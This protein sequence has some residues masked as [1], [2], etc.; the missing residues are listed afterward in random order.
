MK[1]RPRLVPIAGLAAL[2]AAPCLA[3]AQGS[4]APAARPVSF[5]RDIRPLLSN[6]CSACHGP[7][8]KARKA[9]LRLDT[10][11]GVLRTVT[12]YK[13][14]KSAL[15]L[16][17]KQTGAGQ[18]PPAGFL[19]RPTAQQIDLVEQWI[20]QGGKW[21]QH[22]AYAPLAKPAVPSLTALVS[23]RTGSPRAAP[24]APRSDPGRAAIAGSTARRRRTA[25]PPERA[26]APAQVGSAA[27]AGVRNEIDR[28]LMAGLARA[29]VSP[30]PEADRRTLLRR[31]SFD[32]TG[33]P[34]TFDEVRTFSADRSPDAYDR[35]VDRLLASDRFG[36]RMAVVWLDLVRYA[37]TRGYHGDQN[38][39][40]TPYRD[41]V[42]KSFNDNK[43]FDVFTREQIAGDLLPNAGQEQTVA[44][45][46]NKLLMTTE[47]GGAQAKEYM[48][49]YAAD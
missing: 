7:D 32:L 18:M 19:H 3:A 5:Q 23:A 1:I 37:D 16:R 38:Q 21:E 22:W 41:Y 29:G 47:E 39:E 4:A 13:P 10:R 20:A 30:A 45:G 24:D 15:L 26:S 25:S 44:S 12:P 8:E 11:E 17:L 35:A 36:E 43:P 33:L 42:I 14:L 28:F 46:Y 27:D 9:N 31:L 34:P 49:K 40:V 2:L 6:V 48:A